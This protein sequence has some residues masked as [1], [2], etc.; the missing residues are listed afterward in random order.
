MPNPVITISLKTLTGIALQGKI[1]GKQTTEK[2]LIVLFQSHA[3]HKPHRFSE[4]Y[5]EFFSRQTACLKMFR[6]EGKHQ[7]DASEKKS[8]HSSFL[9]S[10]K[11]LSTK[12][13]SDLRVKPLAHGSSKSHLLSPE[14][15][16]QIYNL[17][18]LAP[19]L[20]FL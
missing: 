12:N 9:H 16:M 1:N 17:S 14:E 10:L 7:E 13:S 11:P 15:C 4:A 20:T 19:P 8:I 6:P 18:F 3:E 5:A 2:Q